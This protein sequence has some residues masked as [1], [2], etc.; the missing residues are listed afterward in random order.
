MQIFD[1]IDSN[2]YD[3][4]IKLLAEGPLLKVNGKKIGII[5]VGDIKYQSLNNLIGTLNSHL[6]EKEAVILNKLSGQTNIDFQ[7]IISS[8]SNVT[9]KE[10]LKIKNNLKLIETPTIGLILINHDHLNQFNKL[11]ESLLIK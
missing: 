3:E 4:N 6:K 1:E 7:L 2:S 5:P 9:K 8:P 11:Y 10:I